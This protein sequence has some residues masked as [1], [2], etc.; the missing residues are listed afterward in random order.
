MDRAALFWTVCIPTRLLIATQV[1]SHMLRPSAF[2]LGTRW[3]LFHSHMG[4]RGFFG[5]HAFWAPQRPLHGLLWLTYAL[6]GNRHWLLFD[7][8][9]G[10]WNWST[11]VA[12]KH[13][14]LQ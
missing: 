1:P 6:T 12:E 4:T 11:G 2:L 14:L 3:L 10:A 9:F 5:G 7:A 8:A 13:Q